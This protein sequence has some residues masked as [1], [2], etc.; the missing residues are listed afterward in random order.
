MYLAK[1]QIA[2]D[3]Q[4]ATF[5]PGVQMFDHPFLVTISPERLAS[6]IELAPV[7][8][9][10]AFALAWAATCIPGSVVPQ[11]TADLEVRVARLQMAAEDAERRC[12][13]ARQNLCDEITRRQNAEG[14]AAR[15]RREL[16]AAVGG[17]G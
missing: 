12:T 13:L 1:N 3:A 16:Y 8:Y 14:E 15:L 11:Y 5:R 17:A 10:D 4:E 9:R 6:S 7:A 2:L